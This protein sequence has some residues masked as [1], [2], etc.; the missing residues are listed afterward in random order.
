MLAKAGGIVA[1]G[2]YLFRRLLVLPG[3]LLFAGLLL[4]L[5]AGVAFGAGSPPLSQT[6]G[7]PYRDTSLPSDFRADAPELAARG[8]FNV[9]VRTLHLIDPDQFDVVALSVTGLM[10]FQLRPPIDGRGLVS[11]DR[12]GQQAGDRHVQDDVLGSGPIDPAHPNIPFTFA[13]RALPNARPDKSPGTSPLVI[14][15]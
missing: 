1:K 14:V 8:P 3:T 15:S 4:A 12:P 10:L 9:G 11:G 6:N 13:G 7:V 5:W 2:G